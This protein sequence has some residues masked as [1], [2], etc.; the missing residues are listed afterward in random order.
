MQEYNGIEMY[1]Q[2]SWNYS[3]ITN[4]DEAS[5]PPDAYAYAFPMSSNNNWNDNYYCAGNTD[6]ALDPTLWYI[7][8][9]TGKIPGCMDTGATNYN[10]C[11]TID[12]N[13][14]ICPT[15]VTVSGCTDPSA[16]NYNL[17]AT[18]DDSSCTYDDIFLS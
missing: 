7:C 6:C 11:A 1:L 4:P 13:S 2:P 8:P 16:T 14:C 5:T 15:D 12:D 10:P 18:D 3:G 17:C 9:T